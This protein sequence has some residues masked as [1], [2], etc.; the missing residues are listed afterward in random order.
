[1]KEG[2]ILLLIF[3]C[4]LLMFS[5]TTKSFVR[6]HKEVILAISYTFMSLWFSFVLLRPNNF[7][8]AFQYMKEKNVLYGLYMVIYIV[9]PAYFIYNAIKAYID[10]YHKKNN[11]TKVKDIKEVKTNKKKK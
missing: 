2:F 8:I 7:K 3:L 4:F 11:K 1:M 10:L 5:Q 9:I 6:R